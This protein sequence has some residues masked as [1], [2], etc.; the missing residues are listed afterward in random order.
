MAYGNETEAIR[1]L[2]RYLRQLSYVDKRIPAPPIDGIYESA[3]REAVRAFQEIEGLPATGVV[4]KKTWDLL[5]K[6]Y[7]ESLVRESAPVPIAQFPRL[8]AGYALR[9]GDENFL[10]RLIQYA[11]GELELIYKGF[12]SVPQT[13]VYDAATMAAV[14]SFQKRQGLPETGEVDRETWDALAN[15]Y[16][17]EFGGYLE[18]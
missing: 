8:S 7:R 17:R 16:N 2:Q 13:G 14:K 5:Y 18:Q 6:R 3:T 12:D 1:N 9:E 15:T 11:L 10:V 4:D